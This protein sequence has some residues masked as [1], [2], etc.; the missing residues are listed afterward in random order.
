MCHGKET[1]WQSRHGEQQEVAKNS[2]KG[3]WQSN[4]KQVTEAAQQLVKLGHVTQQALSIEGCYLYDTANRTRVD[5]TV[6]T[7]EENRL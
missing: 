5:P 2:S 6:A 7:S 4:K 3:V 1:G